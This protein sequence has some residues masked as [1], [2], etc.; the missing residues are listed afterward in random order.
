MGIVSTEQYGSSGGGPFS[1]HGTTG[2]ITELR[3]HSGAIVDGVGVAYSS[4]TSSFHGGEGGGGHTL[5]LK[6][7]EYVIE[8]VVRY[9]KFVEAL[10]FKTNM[11]RTIGPWG[12]TGGLSLLS[13]F[14]KASSTVTLVA[15]NHH[16][17][18]AGFHGRCG[19]FIDAIGVHWA[20]TASSMGQVPQKEVM[21]TLT[22]QHLLKSSNLYGSLDRGLEFDDEHYNIH[23]TNL[24]VVSKRDG[25]VQGIAV[26]YFTGRAE[27]H[28]AKIGKTD[29]EATLGM[30]RDEWVREVQVRSND[31]RV[32]CLTFVTNKGRKFGPCGRI[33]EEDK[34]SW[35]NCKEEIV[36]AP[37]GY[38]LIGLKG[39]A[40]ETALDAIGFN[41]SPAPK[42]N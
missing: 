33:P 37:A 4:G 17:A 39:R 38:M 35:D 23:L 22:K 3:V 42:G 8:V 13:G 18:L 26:K 10:T 28:G 5:V 34:E 6:V 24:T 11:N 2:R 21:Q 30:K 14:T 32:L 9:A 27:T 1:T 40:S 25:V 12:G 7:G 16:Y 31:E 36:N 15:P 19:K 41:W 20:P 29:D